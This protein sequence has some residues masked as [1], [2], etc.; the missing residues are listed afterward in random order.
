MYMHAGKPDEYDTLV[1]GDTSHCCE[2]AAPGAGDR[3]YWRGFGG[4]SC[5]QQVTLQHN[6]P[7]VIIDYVPNQLHYDFKGIV[8]DPIGLLC[9]YLLLIHART[10]DHDW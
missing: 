6:N 1:Q 9:V 10:N 8:L 2:R 3:C 4:R 7:L 5:R